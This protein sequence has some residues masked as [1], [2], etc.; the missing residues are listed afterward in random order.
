MNI[1][2]NFKKKPWLRRVH[3]DE[4]DPR[5]RMDGRLVA[6][7]GVRV[8]FIEVTQE[9]FLNELSPAAHGVNSKYMSTRPIY[10]PSG[11]KDSNGKEKYVVVGY[12]SLESVP[13]GWQQQIVTNKI[14]HLANNGFWTAS[15]T[16]DEEAYGKFL[17][18]LDYI[19]IKDAYREA[20]YYTERCGDAA[21]YL[22]QTVSGRI[23][24]E[25]WSLEEGSMLYPRKDVNGNPVIYRRYFVE[26]REM[27]DIISTKSYETWARVDEDEEEQSSTLPAFLRAFFQKAKKERSEDGYV[28]IRRKEAQVG[29]DLSQV[30]YFR[31]PDVSWGPAELTIEALENAVS[32]VANEVKDSAYPVLFVKS[33]KVVSLPP[34][35]TNAK[36]L[37]VKGTTDSLKA[38][39]AKFLAPPDASN[40]ATLHIK[41]LRDNIIRSTSTVIIEPEI[42]KQGAD[43]ST[44]IKILFRPEIEW[45]VQRW[46]YYAKPVRQLVEVC[47]RLVGKVER[48]IAR[49]DKLRVS[50]GMD[51]WVPNNRSEE[52]KNILDQVYARTM[53]RESAIKELENQHIGDY[54]RINKE[55][56]EELEMKQKYG[57]KQDDPNPSAPDITNQA[58]GQ[59]ILK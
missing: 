5:F 26:G 22:Y 55:W 38:A 59:S 23:E 32:Y 2:E 54:E 24:Y 35:K 40:I 58:S 30:I 17:S 52:I 53:S 7:P 19:G 12:D 27:V 46:M 45:A 21:L 28:L 10:G 20:V 15:E 37:A 56:A 49:Y 42:L 18:W 13:L 41:E 9:D 25:V 48:D 47:K 8:G 4:A 14:A 51:P 57:A 3:P 31:V 1:S 29:S 11:T 6:G 43:S 34:S 44:S 39:D 16:E 33:E 36:T 50:I